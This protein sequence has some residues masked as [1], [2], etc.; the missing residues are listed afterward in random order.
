MRKQEPGARIAIVDDYA[1]VAEIMAA[2]LRHMGCAPVTY[3]NPLDF[4]DALKE[5]EFDIVITDLRMPQM[6]GIALLKKVIQRAPKT[7]VIVVSAHAQ[8][9]DAIEALKQGAHDFFE[10]P[11]SEAE[12]VATIKRTLGYEKVLRERDALA[13]RL[14]LV[15][16]KE[17]KTWGIEAF[18][19]KS[20][21]L[22][23]VIKKV[24]LLQKSSK[25]NVLVL[26]ESGTG[27]E[28][29]ARAIH[30]GSERA[31]GPFIAV[32][33]SAI[34]DDLAES[35]LFGHVKGAFTG[36]TSDRKGHFERADG[37]TL[38]LDEI[39]D[40]PRLVQT[41]LLRVLEDGL[42]SPVGNSNGRAVDV[43]VVSAT[44]TNIQERTASGTFRSDLYHRLAGYVMTLPPLR[45]RT[46]DLHPL[47]LHFVSLLSG[48]MGITQPKVDKHF[49]DAL[50][51]HPFPG[52]VRELRNILERALIDAGGTTL[53]VEHLQ[54]ASVAAPASRS[55]E[56]PP[57]ARPD[58]GTLPFNLKEAEKSLVQRAIDH[59]QGNVAAAARLLG[60]SRARVYRTLE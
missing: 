56:P 18:V 19:G 41:K 55:A 15:T 29:V 14:S 20:E 51:S 46:D 40:M 5:T 37:G 44:N 9:Q 43:R 47:V 4:L 60:I 38:F 21:P 32:N 6:D 30:F 45:E 49:M 33:C 35:L 8:K 26:G 52:N 28:L 10:K 53:A 39:G 25:T 59:T 24:R 36:A 31:K 23:A 7:R 1:N 27:K 42:V 13:E 3:T 2:Y 16:E 34:P 12:L 17:A 11:V 57:D 54:M 58:A 22:K 48:E 50:K